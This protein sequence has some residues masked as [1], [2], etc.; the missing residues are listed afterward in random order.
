MKMVGFLHDL[1][2]KSLESRESEKNL[3]F[4]WVHKISTKNS[5]LIWREE[6][7]RNYTFR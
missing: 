7:S 3:A 1:R 4:F 6:S 5:F 2:Q